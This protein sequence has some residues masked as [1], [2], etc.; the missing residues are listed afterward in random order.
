VAVRRAG[1]TASNPSPEFA[2]RPGD[3]LLVMASSAELRK[4]RELLA[5]IE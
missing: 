3:A 5:A 2:I 1:E 4:L